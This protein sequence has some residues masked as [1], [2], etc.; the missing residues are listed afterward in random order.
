M[1]Y[2]ELPFARFLTSLS[3][4]FRPTMNGIATGRQVRY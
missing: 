4:L 1:N 3:R 2:L